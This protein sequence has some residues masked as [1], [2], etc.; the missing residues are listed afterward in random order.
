MCIGYCITISGVWE[1]SSPRCELFTWNYHAWPPAPPLTTSGEILTG[2]VWGN[3]CKMPDTY[4]CVYLNKYKWC[5]MKGWV[6]CYASS[7]RRRS[8]VPRRGEN[9]EIRISEKKTFQYRSSSSLLWSRG[10]GWLARG[11]A[12]FVGFDT[13]EQIWLFENHGIQFEWKICINR[14]RQMR[15]RL[16]E[17]NCLYICLDKKFY[18]FSNHWWKY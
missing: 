17:V 12:L 2:I 3:C 8:Q 11:S 10:E 7:H 13:C 4:M 18:R 16:E 1:L 14:F 6:I 5:K 9:I 15:E